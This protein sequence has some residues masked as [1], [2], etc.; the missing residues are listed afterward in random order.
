MHGHPACSSA[1][2]SVVAVGVLDD[3]WLR[4]LAIMW[5]GN[6]KSAATQHSSRKSCLFTV[7]V[8]IYLKLHFGVAILSFCFWN[9]VLLF[10]LLFGNAL[11]WAWDGQFK[12]CIISSH[13]SAPGSQGLFYV[14]IARH[15]D[16][17]SRACTSHCH[18]LR[19]WLSVV[20]RLVLAGD[21]EH[22]GMHCGMEPQWQSLLHRNF[23]SCK[24]VIHL[25]QSTGR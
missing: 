2:T 12:M 5:T 19:T 8:E 22:R 6:V 3:L 18:S 17:S 15:T 23:R 21:M 24:S 11:N 20:H 16:P 13:S 7:N 25:S 4:P 9:T 14:E 1:R 10:L